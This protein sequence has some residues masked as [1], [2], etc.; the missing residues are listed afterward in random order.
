[1]RMDN[2]RSTSSSTSKIGR[3]TWRNILLVVGM[4][5]FAFALVPLYQVFCDITG[6]NGRTSNL[7][8]EASQIDEVEVD[9]TRQVRVQF[10]A[11]NH[12]DMPWE[13]RPNLAQMEIHPGEI[14]TATYHAQ[15]PTNKPMVAQ[16]IPSVSPN[17]AA[18]YLRKIECFCFEEQTLQ[19]GEAADMPVRFYVHRALPKDVSTLT[20]SYTIFDITPAGDQEDT[21]ADTKNKEKGQDQG[22]HDQS[23]HQ[24]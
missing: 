21:D 6:L 22:A 7:V 24:Y 5:G 1:M 23:D 9:L 10:D 2:K 14:H 17:S 12:I 16:I 11:T 19:P 4:F 3:T 18:S 20:L 15:N 13:F 8:E